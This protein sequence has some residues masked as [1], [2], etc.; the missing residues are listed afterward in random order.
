VAL[1]KCEGCPR[2]VV[3]AAGGD[4][5]DDY[6]GV[7]GGVGDGDVAARARPAAGISTRRHGVLG[8][9]GSGTGVRA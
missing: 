4:D 6:G 1:G 3:V 8:A 2:P 5:G 7:G 9:D